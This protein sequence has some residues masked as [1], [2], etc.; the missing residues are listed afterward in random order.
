[1]TPAVRLFSANWFSRHEDVPALTNVE[2]DLINAALGTAPQ[3]WDGESDVARLE[4]I[5]AAHPAV[6]DRIGAR[7]LKVAIGMRGC[8]GA[9]RFLLE[10]GVVLDADPAVYNVLHEAAWAGAT[11]T[12][13][14]VFESGASDATPVSVKKPHTGWPD[15][16]SLMY[17]AAWGGYPE[18]ARLLIE[19]GAGVHHELKIKGNGERGTTSLH[20][21][22][23]PSPWGWRQR[24]PVG[25]GQARSG[26]HPHR[27]WRRLRHLHRLRPGRRRPRQRPGRRTSGQ[28]QRCR[29]LRHETTAL[30]RAGWI[31]RLRLAA[32]GQRGGRRRG[33]QGPA[34]G[35]AT[36]GGA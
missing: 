36:R 12:L 19:H 16:V 22:V 14:A 17:W 23:A 21:A 34:D 26:A 11:D 6:C 24:A 33:Q 10:R 15:N 7:L 20:E 28:R 4:S 18:L 29:R 31:F 9:V 8:G 27:R 32:V 25:D 35:A 1:M 3:R 13:R 5:V 2:T 30:G